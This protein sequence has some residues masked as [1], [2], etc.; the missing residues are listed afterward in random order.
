MAR[1]MVAF[2]LCQWLTAAADPVDFTLPDVDGN[3]VRL[4]DYRGHWVVVNFWASWCR[5]CLREIP[6]L[7]AFQRDNPESR[8]LG[9]NFEQISA[10]EAKAVATRFEVNYPILKVGEHPL[11]PFEPLNGLPTTALV[12]PDGD[13]VANHAGPV[14]QAMLEEFI[15]RASRRSAD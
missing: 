13:L 7:V 6:E 2:F 3:P 12:T 10:A 8:V 11:V 5:P 15:Q 1:L 9:I 14:T 4:A